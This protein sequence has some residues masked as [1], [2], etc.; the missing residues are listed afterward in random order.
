M[1]CASSTTKIPI[2][3]SLCSLVMHFCN[4]FDMLNFS[5]VVN[6]ALIHGGLASNALKQMSISKFCCLPDKRYA[7]MPGIEV[8]H[9]IIFDV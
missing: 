6:S 3:P 5:G 9:Y 1:Q 7:G 8:K 4:R 2:F